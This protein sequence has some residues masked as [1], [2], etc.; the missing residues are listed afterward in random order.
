[1]ACLRSINIQYITFGVLN[2]FLL[3]EGM[4]I[5]PSLHLRCFAQSDAHASVRSFVFHCVH[6]CIYAGEMMR[7]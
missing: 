7:W 2:D 6:I 3:R 5:Y 4:C 1:M